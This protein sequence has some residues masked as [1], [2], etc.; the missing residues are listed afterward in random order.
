ML[1]H[2]EKGATKSYNVMRLVFD[3]HQFPQSKAALPFLEAVRKETK[4]HISHSWFKS[5][6]ICMLILF[7][8]YGWIKRGNCLVKI[9]SFL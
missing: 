8:I 7:T 4:G 2:L 1:S 6:V 9:L 5:C 3:T